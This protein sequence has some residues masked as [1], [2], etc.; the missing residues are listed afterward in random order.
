[1]MNCWQNKPEARSSF[2]ALTKQLKDM[3]YRD[4]VRLL[5]I[6]GKKNDKF[7]ALTSFPMRIVRRK[8]VK[9]V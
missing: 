1:M 2:T 7:K 5:V 8:I 6:N 3:E 9:V 4:K